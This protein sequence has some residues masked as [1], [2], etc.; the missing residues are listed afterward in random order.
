METYSFEFPPQSEI[1]QFI[2]T[3]N[4][5]YR[6][7]ATWLNNKKQKNRIEKSSFINEISLEHKAT[8]PPQD[9]ME[10]EERQI[11]LTERLKAALKSKLTTF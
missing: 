4:Y 11:S 8:K 5:N 9:Y 2:F 10:R 6:W 7:K 1:F 3:E